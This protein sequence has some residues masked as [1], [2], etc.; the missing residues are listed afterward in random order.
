[1]GVAL[2]LHEAEA[3]TGPERGPSCCPFCAVKSDDQAVIE[4]ETDH[5]LFSRLKV[6]DIPGCGVIIPKRHVMTPF[7][8]TADEWAETHE[9]LVSARELTDRLY[10][11]GGYN[12]GWNCFPVGGQTVPHAHLHLI[13]R[14]SAEPHHAGKG[15]RHWYKQQFGR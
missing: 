6:P 1:M 4:F 15:L 14:F 7:E 9:L 2:D 8:F 12:V 3:V 13:P 5:C 10:K 11:P